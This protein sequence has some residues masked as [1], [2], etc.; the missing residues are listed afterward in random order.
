[1][2]EVKTL[3]K[4]KKTQLIGLVVDYEGYITELEEQ[5]EGERQIEI[6]KIYINNNVESK[7]TEYLMNRIKVI[8]DPN[9]K[10]MYIDELERING[11]FNNEDN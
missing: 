6:Q 3:K 7:T 9:R 5:I 4:L 8:S 11:G 2:T 1:M 10:Q